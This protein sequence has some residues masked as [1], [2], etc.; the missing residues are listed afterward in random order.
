MQG[1]KEFGQ[2]VVLQGNGLIIKN[3][4]DEE[5]NLK[6]TKTKNRCDT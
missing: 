3:T 5:G 6:K 2:S 1:L 4:A